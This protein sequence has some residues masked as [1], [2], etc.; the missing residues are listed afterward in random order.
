MIYL[1]LSFS[2]MNSFV[3]Q[4]LNTAKNLINIFVQFVNNV[5]YITQ[6]QI[7]GTDTLLNVTDIHI[8]ADLTEEAAGAKFTDVRFFPV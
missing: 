8:P 1:G 4:H 2:P 7:A 6:G 5:P 3:S